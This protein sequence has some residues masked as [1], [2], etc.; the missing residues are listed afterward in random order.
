MH[1]G[2]IYTYNLNG[3]IYIMHSKIDDPF[4]QISAP[5]YYQ[6]LENDNWKPLLV[7]NDIFVKE[8]TTFFCKSNFQ[9]F[10]SKYV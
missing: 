7:A 5:L 4:T 10:S 2:G 3:D 8:T 9:L 6:R 1:L